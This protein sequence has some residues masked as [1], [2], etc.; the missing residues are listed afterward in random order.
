MLS[1]EQPQSKLYVIRIR[2]ESGECQGYLLNMPTLH[3]ILWFTWKMIPGLHTPMLEG[4][5]SVAPLKSIPGTQNT[6]LS[7]FLSNCVSGNFTI[8]PRRGCGVNWFILGHLQKY[9][10]S[11]CNYYDN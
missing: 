4:R 3:N 7:S 10:E 6:R 9:T 8:S 5:D 11:N 1:S 2:R